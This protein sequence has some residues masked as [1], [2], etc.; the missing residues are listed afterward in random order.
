MKKKYEEYNY[1][2]SEE[3]AVAS[4]NADTSGLTYEDIEILDTF[5]AYLTKEHGTGCFSISGADPLGFCR[6]QASGLMGD[7]VEISVM[8]LIKT[9]KRSK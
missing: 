6:C 1:Q 8:E 2:L 4:I 3:L 5:E 9:N 7:C